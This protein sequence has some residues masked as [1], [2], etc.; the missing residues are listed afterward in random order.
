[1][2]TKYA[3]VSVQICRCVIHDCILCNGSIIEEGT[4]LKN[5]IVGAQHVVTSNSQHSQEVLTEADRLIEI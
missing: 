4:E 5:C 1:M 3:N 2:Q